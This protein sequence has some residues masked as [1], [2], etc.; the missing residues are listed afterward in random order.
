MTPEN[1]T[2]WVSVRRSALVHNVRAVQSLLAQ[3]SPTPTLIAVVKANAFGHGM[4]AARVFSSAGVDFFAVTALSEALELRA[5]GI[6][7]RVLM[8]LPPL[9]EQADAIVAHDVDATVCDPEN[10][11]ALS[12]AAMRLGKTVRVHLKVDTGMGRLG[13]LPPAALSLARTIAD[14]NRM[15]FAG[16]YTHF[17]HALEDNTDA[18]RG[19]FRVFQSVLAELDAGGIRP[20]LRHCAGSAALVRFPEMRLDAVRPGTI[21]YGQRPSAHVPKLNLRDTWQLNARTVAVRDVPAG[22]RVGYGG[23]WTARRPSR[24]AVIPVGTADGVTL[25]PASIGK[26]LRGLKTLLSG[27]TQWFVTV[28]GQKAPIVGRVSMQIC[29]ADV[30]DIPTVGVGDVAVVPCRRLSASAR[31]VRVYE[32]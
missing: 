19:P 29:T 26:G 14:N 15:D 27:G 20:G 17:A 3:S 5:L 21:L 30:T 13:V 1:E 4:E 24:L 10:V 7:G 22:T 2:A 16:I 31:L 8:F 11:R 9:P 6:T 28:N 23:E 18:V 32:E 12:D 25:A